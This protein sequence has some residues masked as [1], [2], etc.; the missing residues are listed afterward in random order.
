MEQGDDLDEV[1][2]LIADLDVLPSMCVGPLLPSFG[3][4]RAD[5]VGEVTPPAGMA[6]PRRRRRRLAATVVVG[7]ALATTGGV[8]A[9]RWT[10]SHT[11]SF[12]APGMTENDTTEW[13]DT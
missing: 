1:D 4:I 12:G 8:A 11:G 3:E 13:L 2:R 5:L 7:V 6:P 10:S 9:A